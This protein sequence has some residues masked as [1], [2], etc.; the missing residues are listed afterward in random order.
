MVI[1]SDL[2]TPDNTCSMACILWN[3]NSIVCQCST[4]PVVITTMYRESTV[5]WC[6][7]SFLHCVSSSPFLG[8]WMRAVLLHLCSAVD[9]MRCVYVHGR[10][11][12]DAD[13]TATA[14]DCMFWQALD[15]YQIPWRM[16]T[17]VKWSYTCPGRD[18][19]WREADRAIIS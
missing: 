16:I 15:S 6:N 12:V 14:M 5:Y 13:R 2:V 10:F 1:S 3:F 19:E 9:L 7:L 4:I 8:C 18:A 17:Y 11:H